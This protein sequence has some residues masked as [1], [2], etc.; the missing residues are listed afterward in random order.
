MALDLQC[1][2]CGE[3]YSAS[4]EN[5]GSRVHCKRCGQ[6]FTVSMTLDDTTKPVVDPPQ[7]EEL[8]KR[9]GSYVIR[10]LLGSGMMGH[11]YLAYD[12]NLEREVAV[13]VLPPTLAADE[14]R[15]KRF[16]REAKLAA[17]I[18]HTN[19]AQVHQA[20]IEGPFAYIAM[21]Y[22]HGRT[23][24]DVVAVNGPLPWREATR[25][26]R[27]AAAGLRAAHELGLVHR[28][29]K[30]AN[31]VRTPEGTTKILDFGLARADQAETQLTQPGMLLGT[32]AYMAPEQWTGGE[33]DP[34]SD[35]YSLACTWYCLLAGR[36]PFQATS[37]PA[38][39]Y[40]HR[41]EAFPDPRDSVPDL[42]DAV[43]RLLLRGAAKEPAERF[44]SAGEMIAQLDALLATP[45]AA[46]ASGASWQSLADPADTQILPQPAPVRSEPSVPAMVPLDTSR[47]TRYAPGGVKPRRWPWGA[48]GVAAAMLL[49]L[50]LVITFSTK[51]G[52]VE[53]TLDGADDS[54][55]VTLDGETIDIG[56]L[57]EP[58]RL[59][60]G[61]HHLVATSPKFETVT[62]SFRVKRN[63]TTAVDVRFKPRGLAGEPKPRAEPVRQ[64]A[65]QPKPQ[66]KSQPRPEPKPEAPAAAVA[67]TPRPVPILHFEFEGDAANSGS[68]GGG[69]NGTLYGNGFFNSDAARG[70]RAYDTGSGGYVAIP[71]TRL[72]DQITLAA[73]TKLAHGVQNIQTILSSWTSR[74]GGFSWGLNSWMRNDRIVLVETWS[75]AGKSSGT[76]SSAGAVSY[77]SW[78]HVAVTFHRTSGAAAIYVDG[79][80]APP[81][82]RAFAADFS[83]DQPLA[84][85]R[86][87]G[88]MMAM[89]AGRPVTV[90]VPF[91]FTGLIDDLRVY[92]T[93]LTPTEIGEL[94][95][96]SREDHERHEK[97]QRP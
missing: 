17:R 52:T 57:D 62:R 79:K 86:Y 46:L 5:V 68:L 94:G 35:L 58:L 89:L 64:Q 48:A 4:D 85:G 50:S 72:G 84:I 78:H 51:Y 34:R 8:P 96:R 45:G 93:V 69:H 54:V 29:I 26:I 14:T 37:L 40:L 1:P 27:D 39:G 82:V 31:L 2:T 70:N 90:E 38:M 16:L 91:H 12:P 19:V 7:T 33:A 60:V 18:Q 32:P 65:S 77:G 13:K 80:L 6:A 10:R 56:G 61:E 55:R 88:G 15:R 41:H 71:A 23:L 25:V 36:G 95:Q 30:P 97:G 43:C 87:Y 28:D 47:P 73:W 75:Q 21:E 3:P 63:G 81:A 20:G 74:N 49:L 66:P 11:V 42:P 9:V 53:I 24:S 92:D 59:K 67:E 22:V 83:D 76:S 44:Q